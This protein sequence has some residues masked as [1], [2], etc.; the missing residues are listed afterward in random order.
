MQALRIAC[1]HAEVQGVMQDPTQVP[2]IGLRTARRS[3]QLGGSLYARILQ[4][5]E[6]SGIH[7]LGKGWDWYAEI[8]RRLR[9]PLTCPFL[10]CSVKDL[11]HKRCPGGIIPLRQTLSGDVDEIP[12]NLP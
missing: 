10:A 8:Q 7:R 12:A 11:L 3:R 9:S 1:D 5:R 6:N 4:S 2:T